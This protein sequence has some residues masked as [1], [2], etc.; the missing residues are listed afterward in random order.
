MSYTGVIINGVDT[1][2]EWGLILLEDLK[3]GEAKLK[4]T[5]VNIPG[6]DGSL[7]MSYGLTDGS[8]VF[9]MRTISFTLFASGITKVGQRLIMRK[10][11]DEAAVNEIRAALQAAYHG[12]EVN[13]FLPDDSTHYFRGVL[14][15]GDKSKFNSGQI[16]ITLT[17][18][19]Y[20][21][22]RAETSVAVTI[23]SSGT[24]TVT[25]D[26]EQRRVV[27]TITTTGN[28][29]VQKGSRTWAIE[30]GTTRLSGLYLDAG[31]TELAMSG[32]AGTEVTITYQEGRL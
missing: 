1:L 11:K 23:P 32:T 30:P 12:R 8:P 26:N 27:P 22:K 15:V 4:S 13:V 19:P 28:L 2:E 16:P 21:L 9:D 7:N 17:A 24:I 14:A 6:A 29:S 18:Y 20:R 3:I 10:A 5:W 31:E 25:L